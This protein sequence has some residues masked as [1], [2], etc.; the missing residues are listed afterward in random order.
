MGGAQR[1]AAIAVLT[2]ATGA[3]WQ[4]LLPA[5][6]TGLDRSPQ[7][8][9]GAALPA[10]AKPIKGLGGVYVAVLNITGT[11]GAAGAAAASLE[12]R[13]VKVSYV[14]DGVF[15]DRPTTLLYRPGEKRPAQALAR[16][17]HLPA[18]K[19]IQ[20]RLAPSIGIARIVVLV[21]PGGV[22]G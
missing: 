1:L 14:G 5:I 15:T 10:A 11:N 9:N 7:A 16:A 22:G 19:P 13:G 12:A 8:A 17:L 18:P 6:D 3:T 2:V 4:L 20:A 21:G